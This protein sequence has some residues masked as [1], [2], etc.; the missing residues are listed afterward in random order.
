MLRKIVFYT[1]V[2]YKLIKKDVINREDYK[3]EYN[4]VS[5]TYSNWL[6]EMRKFTDKIIKPQYMVKDTRLKILDFACGTDRCS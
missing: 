5:R 6:N 3:K 1:K 4:K 2:G